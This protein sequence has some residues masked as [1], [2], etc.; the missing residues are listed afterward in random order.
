[1]HEC[2]SEDMGSVNTK[3]ENKNVKI[4]LMLSRTI[5]HSKVF[6]GDLCVMKIMGGISTT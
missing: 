3:D 1:M 4:D 6:N 5:L 2:Y